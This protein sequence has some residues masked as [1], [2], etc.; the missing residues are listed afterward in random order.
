MSSLCLRLVVSSLL[1][2]RR[3]RFK[4]SRQTSSSSSSFQTFL[5]STIESRER[6]KTVENDEKEEFE[7]R[8][9]EGRGRG[10]W[11]GANTIEGERERERRRV[12][13]CFENN[14]D[15][16]ERNRFLT[17]SFFF[18]SLDFSKKKEQEVKKTGEVKR[19]YTVRFDFHQVITNKI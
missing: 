14:D 2:R 1:L 6:K 19:L 4:K 13:A 11:S 15:Y 9:G 12:A 18:F 3:R 8:R 10:R 16:K 17:V 7:Q 5:D